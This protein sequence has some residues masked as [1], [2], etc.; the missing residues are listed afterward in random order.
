ML[1][2]VTVPRGDY[3]LRNCTYL[4][5]ERQVSF[6]QAQTHARESDE[7][8]SGDVHSPDLH[9]VIASRIAHASTITIITRSKTVQDR[10]SR[11]CNHNH[12]RTIKNAERTYN[13]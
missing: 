4:F 13:M 1:A 11:A 8:D 7:D 6:V 3:S 10:R 2:R 5:I 9:A 12:T